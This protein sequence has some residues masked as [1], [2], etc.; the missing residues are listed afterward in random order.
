MLVLVCLVFGIAYLI[1]ET[2]YF[3][4]ETMHMVFG[5]VYLVFGKVYLVFETLGVALVW[6]LGSMIL[7]ASR[8]AVAAAAGGLQQNYSVRLQLLPVV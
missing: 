3:V 5:K 8:P 1:F 7:P 4:L 6:G 2:E